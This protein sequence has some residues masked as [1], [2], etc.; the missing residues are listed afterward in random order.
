MSESKT[1]SEAEVLATSG[2]LD[3]TEFRTILDCTVE[4][5]LEKAW[6]NQWKT[7]HIEFWLTVKNAQNFELVSTAILERL[8]RINQSVIV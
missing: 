2:D 1:D 6:Q 3:E 5:L 7:K 4:E 8:E